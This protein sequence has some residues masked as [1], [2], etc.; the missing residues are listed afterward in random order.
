MGSRYPVSALTQPLVTMWPRMNVF[1][2]QQHCV[3]PR[4]TAEITPVP[5]NLQKSCAWG[6]QH[7]RS[8]ELRISDNYNAFSFC[9][10][11]FAMLNSSIRSVK[12]AIQLTNISPV[13]AVCLLLGWAFHVLWCYIMLTI[14]HWGPGL[15]LI[16]TLFQIRKERF[17]EVM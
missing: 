8:K 7:G 15:L 11:V 10:S 3:L 17:G 2:S 4:K 13:L 9:R 6:N 14:S 12:E 16:I 1:T 5:W